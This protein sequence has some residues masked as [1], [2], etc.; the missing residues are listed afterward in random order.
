MTKKRKNPSTVW[1]RQAEA[2]RRLGIPRTTLISRLARGDFR[3]S[4]RGGTLFV[5]LPSDAT[6]PSKTAAA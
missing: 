3:T 6:Q 1:Y 2:A 4:K 5:A